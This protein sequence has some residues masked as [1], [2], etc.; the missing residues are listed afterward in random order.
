MRAR[1]CTHT[2]TQVCGLATR[3]G[4]RLDGLQGRASELVARLGRVEAPPAA[5]GDEAEGMGGFGMGQ[6]RDAAFDGFDM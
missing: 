4:G 5:A 1:A 3:L 2:R 6:R